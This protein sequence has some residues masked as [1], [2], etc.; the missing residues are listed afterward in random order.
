MSKSSKDPIVQILDIVTGIKVEHIKIL[1]IVTDIKAEQKITNTRLDKLEA[2]QK[3][4]EAGQKKTDTRL[5]KLEAGQ[6]KLEAGQK[7]LEVGQKKLEEG[8]KFTNMTLAH[9]ETAVDCEFSDIR[10]TIV[11][12]QKSLDGSLR[13]L[14]D[15]LDHEDRIN[16]IERDIAM[17]K[18]RSGA[19]V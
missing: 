11:E 6:K 5:D 10:E 16:A 3:R 18:V 12:N 1:D 2:G 9:L 4:L 7:K 17:L 15:M 19:R 8:Q 13:R 14:G